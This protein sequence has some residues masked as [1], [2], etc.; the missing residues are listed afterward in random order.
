VILEFICLAFFL[1]LYYKERNNE[2]NKD[3]RKNVSAIKHLDI[4][5][6]KAQNLDKNKKGNRD[7]RSAY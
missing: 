3:R 4:D 7:L 1:L 2:A 5:I 6:K